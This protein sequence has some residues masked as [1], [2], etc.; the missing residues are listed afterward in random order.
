MT[1]RNN[2]D[3]SPV[4]LHADVNAIADDVSAMTE[5]CSFADVLKTLNDKRGQLQSL[6]D[7][8]R[9]LRSRGFMYWPNLEQQL[10]EA[11]RSAD[12][13]SQDARNETHRAG[14]QLRNVLTALSQRVAQMQRSHRLDDYAVDALAAERD[15]AES[16]LAAVETRIQTAA[17]PFTQLVDTVA[18]GV[19]GSHYTMDQFD[20]ASFRC[21]AEENPLAV[22]AATWEDSPQGP[23]NGIFY[24]T[25]LVLR[26]ETLVGQRAL[27]I[28][29]PVGHIT[30][31]EDSERGWFAKDEVLTL[32]FAGGGPAQVT[33]VMK[34]ADSKSLDQFIEAARSG[35]IVSWKV[36]KPNA[37]IAQSAAV[38]VKWP[39]KCDNC[40][41]AISAPVRG[42]M[43]VVCA[44]CKK[45]YPVEF[46]KG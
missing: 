41:A 24:L 1:R 4:D 5:R 12:K 22:A 23:I 32:R 8:L 25:D 17:N 35:Q 36:Q 40:G 46:A 13:V 33:L 44:Y 39:N 9:R 42:Q 3:D 6:H 43:E 34:S 15:R 31:S 16:E 7:E 26:F 27:L 18:A 14:Q 38:P 2:A 29:K 10:S 30:A 28:E 19:A 11:Q 45:N 37:P 20:Q 21:R